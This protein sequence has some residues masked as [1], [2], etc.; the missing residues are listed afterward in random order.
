METFL[1]LIRHSYVFPLALFFYSNKRNRYLLT[2]AFAVTH[3]A[4]IALINEGEDKPML[5][6]I[7]ATFIYLS[8]GLLSLFVLRF[9]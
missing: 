8:F 3:I 7:S 5:L 4:N 9:A 6:Q 2:V 1:F